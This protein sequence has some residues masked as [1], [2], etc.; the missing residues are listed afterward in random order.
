MKAGNEI[1]VVFPGGI[2]SAEALR[3]AAYIFSGKSGT[4]V[5]VSGF[6]AKISGAQSGTTAGEFANEV[7]NQQCRL[8]LSGKN[9]KIAGILVT[10]ALLSAAGEK[11]A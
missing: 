8:D 2:Y 5:T 4:S 9:S 11:K 3:L 7:L 6:K 10:K 1:T